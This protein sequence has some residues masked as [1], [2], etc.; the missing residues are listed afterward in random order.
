MDDKLSLRKKEYT[1]GK[2]MSQLA[3]AANIKLAYLSKLYLLR[4]EQ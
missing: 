3:N 4:Y 2:S 1:T